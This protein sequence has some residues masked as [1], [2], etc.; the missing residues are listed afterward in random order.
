MVEGLSGLVSSAKDIGLHY[1]FRVELFNLAVSHFQ[2]ANDTL[3][4]EV[5]S[6]DWE[7]VEY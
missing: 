2:Y 4:V 6:V 5:L 3:L 1:G 7:S